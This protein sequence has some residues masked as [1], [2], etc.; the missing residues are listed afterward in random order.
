MGAAGLGFL[1]GIAGG[2]GTSQI[3][4]SGQDDESG[5]RSWGLA[6]GEN[7]QGTVRNT[8]RDDICRRPDGWLPEALKP[9]PGARSRSV[10]K[11]GLL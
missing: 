1:P 4:M 6:Q 2:S 9:G 8:A 10:Q 5:P 7:G 11:G 3:R